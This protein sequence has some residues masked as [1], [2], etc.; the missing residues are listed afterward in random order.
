MQLAKW[1]GAHVIAVASGK[2]EAILR[3]LGADDFI[4]Y[5]KTP[6]EDVVND[7]DLVLDAV[8]P[9]ASRF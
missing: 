7:V 5:T 4:D 6:A 9:A 8:G 2:H 1:K 3:D